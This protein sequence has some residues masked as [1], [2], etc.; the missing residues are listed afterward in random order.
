LAASHTVVYLD[1]LDR[2][3]EELPDDRRFDVELQPGTPRDSHIRIIREL[4]ATMRGLRWHSA[5]NREKN[6]CW[7]MSATHR[8]NDRVIP[9]R[10]RVGDLDGDLVLRG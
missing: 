6:V 5:V 3:A 2:C 8:S 1:D 9:I 4:P 10:H 7:R